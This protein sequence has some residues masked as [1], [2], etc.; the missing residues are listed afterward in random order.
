L[1]ES[2][3]LGRSAILDGL[4]ALRCDEFCA[5]N[6][7]MAARRV[8][9]SVQD[10]LNA[11]VQQRNRVLIDKGV[12]VADDFGFEVSRSGAVVGSDSEGVVVRE[13]GSSR[14]APRP[15]LAPAARQAADVVC[16]QIGAALGEHLMASGLSVKSRQFGG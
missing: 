15:I 2:E 13:I 8:L 4:K 1:G 16:E 6:L 9:K 14:A 7:D 11:S 5:A 12:P 3:R 10:E